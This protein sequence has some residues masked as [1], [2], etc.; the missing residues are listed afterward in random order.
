MEDK[1]NRKM[2]NKAYELKHAWLL[3]CAWAGLR[4]HMDEA[5]MEIHKY[6][7]L[8]KAQLKSFLKDIEEDYFDV[9][10]YVLKS[11]SMKRAR[12]T[13]SWF[14][15]K[16]LEWVYANAPIYCIGTYE[17]VDTQIG[18]LCFE[19][20]IET[21]P[22]AEIIL[23][24]YG[25]CC[26][27]HPEYM[28][29]RD[30]SLAHN[31]YLD[32]E[33]LIEDALSTNEKLP[34]HWGENAIALGRLSCVA[35]Y[36]LMEGFISGLILESKMSSRADPN[37]VAKLEKME[38]TPLRKRFYEVPLLLTGTPISSVLAQDE[39][40][41]YFGEMKQRRDAFV[42]CIPG[43]ALN[44]QGYIRQEYFNDVQKDK[45]GQTVRLTV[46]FIRAIWRHI[47]ARSG[48]RWLPEQETDG[49]FMGDNLSLRHN[50]VAAHA[51]TEEKHN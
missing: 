12:A 15:E 22:Y 31:L 33:Q 9:A 48:P 13:V 16:Y 20:K 26:C 42:H 23:Q 6:E 17:E 39:I 25:G 45:V 28:L 29:A 18:P 36:N 51:N 21:P 24:G 14:S 49:R 41:E 34:G 5:S 46:K 37:V 11:P 47:Y 44:K 27:R 32:A 35:A 7:L 19:R 8:P 43:T 10:K 4:E 1:A 38:M 30:L 40:S 3:C 2:V 50:S